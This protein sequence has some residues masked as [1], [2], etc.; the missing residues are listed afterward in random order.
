MMI[1]TT[2]FLASFHYLNLSLA[3]FNFI[4]VPPLDGSR[5]L[6]SFLPDKLY[7]GV[8]KYEQIISMVLIV[9]LVTDIL[10]NPLLWAVQKIS[11]GIAFIIPII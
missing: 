4:P 7:F 2:E 9:L 11:N 5:V 10:D 6:Y 3:I 1:V 8:M